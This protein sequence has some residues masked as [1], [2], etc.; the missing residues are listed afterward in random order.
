MWVGLTH[1][2]TLTCSRGTNSSY[3]SRTLTG[4]SFEVSA[5]V[6]NTLY[7]I[8]N[9]QYI[10]TPVIDM[11]TCTHSYAIKSNHKDSNWNYPLSRICTRSSWAEPSHTS[12]FKRIHAQTHA[13]P[14][15]C[16]CVCVHA[17]VTVVVLLSVR[18]YIRTYARRWTFSSTHKDMS[19]G[20]AFLKGR[21]IFYPNL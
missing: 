3:N 19:N 16:V 6:W 10:R 12:M 9:T 15:L 20:V 13:S 14:D 18:I 21:I 4:E 11:V 8:H 17:C 2:W 5:Q 1:R 7:N